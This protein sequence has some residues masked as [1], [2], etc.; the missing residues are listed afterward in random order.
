M[1]KKITQAVFPVLDKPLIRQ[2]LGK[3]AHGLRRQ[4]REAMVPGRCYS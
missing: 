2:V 3:M 4:S 1:Q